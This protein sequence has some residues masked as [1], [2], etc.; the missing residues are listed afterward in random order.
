MSDKDAIIRLGQAA[1]RLLNDELANLA[2]DALLD[3]LKRG[4]MSTRPDDMASRE[5][6]Y[7]MVNAVRLVVQKLETWRDNGLKAA[8]DI[9]VHDAESRGITAIH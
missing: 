2:F 9:K 8:E 7:R 1:E 5:G 3:D 6:C 4:W